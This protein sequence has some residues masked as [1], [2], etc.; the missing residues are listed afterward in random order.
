MSLARRDYR[1]FGGTQEGVGGA[2]QFDVRR[3]ADVA[4]I[5]PAGHF[6]QART[7][8]RI[9]RLD[10]VGEAQVAQGVFVGQ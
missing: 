7:D 6:G 1:R 2:F 5:A 3:Q 4:L 8:V 10:G 9:V